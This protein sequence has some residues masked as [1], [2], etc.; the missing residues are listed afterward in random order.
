MRRELLANLLL[1]AGFAAS[2]AVGSSETVERSV[3]GM[4]IVELN[5]F[6]TLGKFHSRDLT[7]TC[8]TASKNAIPSRDGLHFVIDGKADYFAGSNSYWIPFLKSN[9]DVDMVMSH[10]K[11]SGLKVLRVWGFNDVNEIP[12][13]GRVWFHHIQNGASTINEGPDG[14]QRL[15]YVVKSAETHDVKL[16]VNFVNNW[17]D[18]GGIAAYNTAFG[19]N[20][21][22][23]YT[24]EASQK[25]YRDYIK[26]VIGR[27]K[28]SPAIFAWELANEPRC[29]GCHT[30]VIYDWVKSTS[31][32]I[33]S[34]EPSRM[35]CIGDGKCLRPL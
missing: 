35:V 22:T 9:S 5:P 18:Y 6:A 4:L 27:Y 24:D 14:L 8:S 7:I 16:I 26:A 29:R 12:T 1:Y 34:L 31:E 20:A 25:S 13:D 28:G 17:G 30:S 10:L 19:G 23:W 3:E 33:K 15:D 21:T 32:Y 2:Y 11:Q